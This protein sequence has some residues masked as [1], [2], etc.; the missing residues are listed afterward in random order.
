MESGAS[1]FC[2]RLSLQALGTSPVKLS[3]FFTMCGY[4]DL[5]M[6]QKRL[7]LQWESL[8][9]ERVCPVVSGAPVIQGSQVHVV[10]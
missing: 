1:R 7:C 6:S 4:G 8:P 3:C 5:K 9:L 2:L 10:S